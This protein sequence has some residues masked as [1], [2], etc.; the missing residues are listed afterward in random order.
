VVLLTV[1]ASS[2]DVVTPSEGETV[3]VEEVGENELEVGKGNLKIS[4]FA[5]LLLD[6]LLVSAKFVSES[7][8]PS[9]SRPELG[10]STR[11]VSGGRA[12]KNKE[13]FDEVIYPLADSLNA[14][15][16]ASRAAVDAG[17][18]DNSLQVNQSGS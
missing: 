2:F 11:V 6:S 13:T 14:A 15:V 3:K 18:A 17:Y 16:G 4:F 8:T 12:L 1:R 9:S 10:T 7:L 5:S